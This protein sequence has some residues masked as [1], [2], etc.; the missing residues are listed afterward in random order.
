VSSPPVNKRVPLIVL[1]LFIC[2]GGL[3]ARMTPAPDFTR[4]HTYDA[5]T[6]QLRELVGA[7]ASIAQMVEIGKTSE[8]RSVWAVE[9]AGRGGAPAN[10]RPALLVAGNFEGDQLFGSELALYAVD[11]LLSSYD[12]D[13]DVKGRID[14]QAFYII[15]RLN[16]DAAEGMFAPVKTGRKCNMSPSD[17]DNDGR[18]DEDGPEDL[19]GDGMITMMRVKDPRGIW[20]IHPDDPRLM[21]RADPQRGET[22]AYSVYSEGIDSDGDGFI[23]ED[24][25]G[26]VDLN[27]NFQHRYPY[28]AP[29]AGRYMVSEP[30]TRAL[31]DYVLKH[32]NI[33]A[34]LTFGESDN[35]VAAPN[36]RGELAA[37]SLLDMLSFGQYAVAEA[38]GV[39]VF[40]V[41]PAN[42]FGFMFMFED[43]DEDSPR[44]AARPQTQQR[45]PPT[46]PAETVNTADLEYF[47]TVSEK[48]RALTGIRS[49]SEVR[50]PAGAFFEYAYYQF[51]VP[52]F[53]T[54]GWGLP[55]PSGPPQG[56]ER[57]AT[58]QEEA[59]P[60]TQPPEPQA[61][62]G[63]ASFDLRMLKWM[64]D[65]KIDGFVKWTPYKHPK[66][67]EV[68]IGGFRPYSASDPPASR[69]SELGKSHCDFLLYLASILPRVSVAG[70]T[71]TPLGG[72]LFRI[73]VEIQNLGFL[74]TATAQGVASR[75]V[76]PT[77]VQLEVAPEDIV[78][79]DA[80][81]SFFQALAGSGRRQKYQWIVKGKPGTSVQLKLMSQKGG[82]ETVSLTLQ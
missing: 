10:T 57:G 69:I 35:L 25:P 55:A 21:R 63:T 51:G 17:D 44:G 32:R 8:G 61:G 7:H 34:V 11:F 76:K 24:P 15:P 71:V 36:R 23:N 3:S 43:E 27:R 56:S 81:T 31:M 45:R 70:K 73:A 41:G 30:E 33:A 67:G 19:N 29:D 38:R 26:G 22:G 12:I 42:P 64:D 50:T 2:A 53:S 80:K 48:Y 62:A 65:E 9:I 16:P 74:P 68:E 14:A 79:G 40:Q 66:L 18:V 82:T 77:M 58:R 52:A 60:G 46:R 72:S 6:A 47:R 75:S 37:P 13:P 20:M 49:T 28:Y 5:M 54:P 1:M 78:S 59:S 39:G 4:Y